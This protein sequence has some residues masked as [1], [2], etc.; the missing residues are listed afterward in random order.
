MREV[1]KR[2]LIIASAFIVVIF[3]VSFL[4]AGGGKKEVTSLL[5]PEFG[6]V[7]KEYELSA[8]YE[9]KEEA[10]T[11]TINERKLTF[12]E[13]QELFD[14]GY[15][16]LLL[17]MNDAN[18]DLDKISGDIYLPESVLDGSLKIA[19]YSDNTDYIENNGVLADK[20][21]KE[22][23]KEGLI[24]VMYAKVSVQDYSARFEVPVYLFGENIAANRGAKDIIE[25][26]LL[27]AEGA[28]PHS[29]EVLL[30]G[31]I[32]ESGVTYYEKEDS[33]WWKYPLLAA[34]IFAAYLFFKRYKENKEKEERIRQLEL[35]Y[36]PIITK[37]T[38]LIGA[39]SSI[40]G[41]WGR[42]VE[43]YKLEKTVNAAY[44]EMQRVHNEMKNGMSE[45]VA[46]EVF[47]KRCKLSM[48]V[49]FG[50]LLEQ[51]LRK[52]TKGLSERLEEE[53][54]EAFENRKALAIKLGE[55]AGTKLLLPMIMLLAIVIVICVVPAFLSM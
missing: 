55:E 18:G 34:I 39:G 41:A 24:V 13:A 37:F 2:S 25:E 43:D 53:V 46:Y 49:R 51:N 20:A 35:S 8:V 21:Y 42:L 31:K 9:G 27:A 7:S 44:E 17:V 1:N 22:L 52:G 30:P 36:S 6:E 12:E 15:D 3:T 5:R 4:V 33:E 45:Q 50:N 54:R 47:G 32:G 16:E 40:R 48:Y 23:P 14:K 26:E 38:L 28:K 29:E 11:V 19:W 10:V